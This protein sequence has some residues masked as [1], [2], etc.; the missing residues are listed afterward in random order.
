M[1]SE[2]TDISVRQVLIYVGVGNTSAPTETTYS[3]AAIQDAFSSFGQLVNDGAED[4]NK[5][6][7]RVESSVF[8]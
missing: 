7:D 8:S 1:R 5:L 6:L 3:G 2:L 4:C